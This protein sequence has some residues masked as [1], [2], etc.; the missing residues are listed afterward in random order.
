M[1]RYTK[2]AMI[3]VT[4]AGSVALYALK[5]DT[6]KEAAANVVLRGEIAREREAMRI[7]EAE[8][9]L[10]NQPERLQKLA[11]RHLALV[12]LQPEQIVDFP[13]LPERPKSDA[14]TNLVRQSSTTAVVGAQT[15]RIGNLIEG[16]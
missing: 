6:G 1:M 14:M 2:F 8:W 4:F 9:S 15:D 12:P 10:L 5:Y 11:K 3:A 7:L 13:G 16:N